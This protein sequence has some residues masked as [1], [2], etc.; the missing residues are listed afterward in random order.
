MLH[1]IRSEYTRK[2]SRRVGRGGK[3]GTTAG[4][5][6]K[7]QRAHAGRRIRPAEHDYIIRLP[8]RRG[9]NNPSLVLKPFPI[10]LSQIEAHFKANDRVTSERIFELGL[11]RRGKSPSARREVKI[12]G[13]GT[14]SKPLV[15]SGVL[16]SHGAQAKITKAGGTVEK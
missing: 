1:K 12:L 4:R 16:M 5:G 14:I 8:K 11:A 7:G 10:N 2:K 9:V 13:G 15:F 3:R 6:T